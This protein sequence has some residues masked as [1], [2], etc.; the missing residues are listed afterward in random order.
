MI[1]SDIDIKKSII[2]GEFSIKHDNKLDIR[3]ASICM[4]L[5]ENITIPLRKQLEVDIRKQET[6][7]KSKLEKINESNGH[8]LLPGDFLLGATIECISLSNSLT[9]QLSNISGLARLGLNT[10]LSTFVS[11][12]FGANLA[13]PL[14]LEIHNASNFP[15]RIFPGMRIC[16]LLLMRLESQASNGYDQSNP[17]KY[18][19]NAPQDSEFYKNTGIMTPNF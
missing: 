16:H 2:N 17:D 18:L 13:R 10:V 8:L 19:T 14:T 15:I 4:H 3:S 9:G 11:P 12:G 1:L 6:Y 5:S 7:P